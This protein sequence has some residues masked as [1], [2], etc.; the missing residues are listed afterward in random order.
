MYRCYAQ[1]SDSPVCPLPSIWI[2]SFRLP[3]GDRK[4]RGERSSLHSTWFLLLCH[5]NKGPS[6]SRTM[7]FQWEKEERVCKF[8]FNS[9]NI[10]YCTPPKIST[11]SLIIKGI[12]LK[13]T[14]QYYITPTRVAIIQTATTNK[15]QQNCNRYQTLVRMWRNWNTCALLVGL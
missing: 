13:A 15:Q 7:W 1:D 11:I 4:S 12:R 6:P 14:V 8:S 10:G 2:W 5:L 9:R 3:Q